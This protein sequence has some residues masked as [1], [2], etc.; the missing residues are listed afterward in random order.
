VVK[1]EKKARRPSG[2]ILSKK[3]FVTDKAEVI[4]VRLLYNNNNIILLI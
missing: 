4:G 1:I 2:L 3:P